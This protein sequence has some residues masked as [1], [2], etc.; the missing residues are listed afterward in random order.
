MWEMGIANGNRIV[1]EDLTGKVTL[2]EK[3]EGGE[4]LSGPCKGKHSG[5]HSGGEDPQTGNRQV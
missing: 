5:R 2:A 3:P 1:R 4:D